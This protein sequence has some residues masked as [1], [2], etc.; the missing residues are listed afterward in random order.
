MV[1]M[2]DITSYIKKLNELCKRVAFGPLIVLGFPI[3]FWGWWVHWGLSGQSYSIKLKRSLYEVRSPLLK[4]VMIGL[5]NL[6]TV[7]IIHWDLMGSEWACKLRFA[8]L[9]GLL[10]AYFD[11]FACSALSD[12]LETCQARSFHIIN[13]EHRVASFSWTIYFATYGLYFENRNGLGVMTTFSLQHI[14]GPQWKWSWATLFISVLFSQLLNMLRT[15]CVACCPPEVWRKMRSKSD[16]MDNY[17]LNLKV[18]ICVYVCMITRYENLMIRMRHL[19]VFEER[20]LLGEMIGRNIFLR[21][22]EEVVLRNCECL[23]HY[24]LRRENGARFELCSCGH[25]TYG[26]SVR[27]SPTAYLVGSRRGRV[28]VC[29]KF[30]MAISDG[31]RACRG[32]CVTFGEYCGI[33]WVCGLRRA[34]PSWL[35][36]IAPP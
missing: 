29:D 25:N 21:Q 5:M 22:I 12:R 3:S 26:L 27:R 18:R 23:C 13:Y 33:I 17:R 36:G 4:L 20:C 14:R 31:Q 24:M 11:R 30:S 6:G 19:L 16:W 28:S 10:R 2:F 35:C 34:R 32:G 1:I 15:I 8:T 7:S 9:D